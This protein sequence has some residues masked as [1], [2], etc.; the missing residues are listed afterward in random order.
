MKHLPIFL[1]LLVFTNVAYSQINAVTETGDKVILYEDST[2]AYAAIDTTEADTIAINPTV[3]TKNEKADFLLKSTTNNS[4]V[5]LNSKEWKFE[6]SSINP[7]AEYQIF[8]KSGSIYTL[9]I[10]EELSIPLPALRDIVIGNTS[11]I[12]D[13]FQLIHEEYRTVNGMKVLQLEFNA[14]IQGMNFTYLGYYFS[15]ENGTTQL[16]SYTAENLFDKYRD[17][18]EDL[19]NGLVEIE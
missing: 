7:Q 18:C 1:L 8:H 5:W 17:R 4:G 15:T 11:S 3:F 9:L 2:W 10:T 14:K 19:L 12:A 6:K 13:K 16:L